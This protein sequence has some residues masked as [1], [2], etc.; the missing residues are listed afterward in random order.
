[1]ILFFVVVF[2]PLLINALCLTK[3]TLAN[4]VDPNQR[5]CNLVSDLGHLCLHSI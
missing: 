5:L 1:M 4:S 3:G 2:F